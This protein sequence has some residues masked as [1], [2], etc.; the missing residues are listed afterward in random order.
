MKTV[1]IIAAMSEELQHF[2]AHM[3][4]ESQNKNFYKGKLFGVNTILAV[5]GIGKVNAA[6]CTQ[7]LIDTYKINYLINIGVAGA[8]SDKLKIGD[9]VAAKNLVQHDFDATAFNL[10]LGEIPRL[11][12]KFFNCDKKILGIIKNFAAEKNLTDKIH[13]GTIATGDKFVANDSAKRFIEKNFQAYGTEMEGAAIAQVCFLNEIPFAAIRI[14]SDK[15]NSNAAENYKKFMSDATKN[16]F[17][18]VK[19]IISTH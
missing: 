8:I 9:I 18:L 10:Q 17:E 7:M 3:Q 5:S 19:F 4:L 2:S 1:G 15:S 11:Q 16:L 6:A 13:L 14:I 12:K